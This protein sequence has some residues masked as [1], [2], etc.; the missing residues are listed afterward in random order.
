MTARSQGASWSVQALPGMSPAG[1][2]LLAAVSC[3]STTSCM[4][5]GRQEVPAPYL[6][7]R[8]AGDRP[9][10]EHWDGTTWASGAGTVP[11]RAAD[12]EL[13][14]VDC[15]GATCVAVGSYALR[16]GDDRPLAE[17]WDG[18]RWSLRLPP[19]VRTGHEASDAVLSDVAC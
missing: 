11:P 4:A 6:G 9:G 5:V 16:L 17:V 8:S 19:R 18:S 2:S 10:T 13:R 1:D 14:G 3:P 12:A 15:T 7:A